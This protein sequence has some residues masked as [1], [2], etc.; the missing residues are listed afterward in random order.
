MKLILDNYKFYYRN[1]K[2]FVYS[3]K[4]YLLAYLVCIILI[5][6]SSIFRDLPLYKRVVII[7]DEAMIIHNNLL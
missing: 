4:L 6:K 7:L 5:I 1:Y 3:L 2:V